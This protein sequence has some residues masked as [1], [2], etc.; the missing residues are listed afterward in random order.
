MSMNVEYFTNWTNQAHRG[1]LELAIL[2]DIR[3]RGMYGY[4]IEGRFSKSNGLFLSR[5]AI[6]KILR[7][8]KQQGLVKAKL[9]KS[10][11]GPKRKYYELTRTGTTTLTQMNNYWQTINRKTHSIEKGK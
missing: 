9:I 6:Y 2:N 11:D 4:E 10:P 1:V 7:R 3:N 8:F 5:G